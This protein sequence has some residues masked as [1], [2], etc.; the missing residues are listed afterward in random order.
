MINF[1]KNLILDGAMGTVLQEFVTLS[2]GYPP[3][4]LSIENSD[5]IC[6]IHKAYIDAGS[7]VIST[8]TFGANPFKHTEYKEMIKKSVEIALDAASGRCVA[9][10]I[11]PS[12][13]LFGETL[14]FDSCYEG[15]KSVVLAAEDKTDFILF[16]TFTDLRELRTAVLAAK[17]NS[18]LPVVACM[19]FSKNGRTP[20]GTDVDSFVLTVIAAGADG[21]GANCSVGP[22]EMIDVAK[23]M[24]QITDKPVFIQ[25]NAGIPI[26][27]NGV[28]VFPV[29]KE[30]FADL[31]AKIKA[32]GVR[33]IGGCCGTNPE[34]IKLLKEKLSLVECQ[35]NAAIKRSAVCCSQRTAVADKMLVVGER[36]NP[37]GKKKFKEAVINGDYDYITACGI[38]QQEE[39][40]DTLDVNVG[41]NGVDEKEVMQKVT[42]RLQTVTDLPL[43]IDTSSPA[44]LE[45]ALRRY[46]GKAIINSVNASK[47]SLEEVLPL[48]VRFGAAVIGLTLDENGI[49]KTVEGRVKLAKKITQECVKRGIAKED[50][51]IDALTLSE[52]SESGGALVTLNT[53]KEVKKLGVKTVLGVSNVSF[54]MPLRNDINAAFLKL[55]KEAGLDL[56]I[57]NPTF[58]N[59]KPS[60]QATDFILNREGATEAYLAYATGKVEEAL[61]GAEVTSDL[62]KAILTGQKELSG[63]I[64]EILIKENTAEE[65]VKTYV[66]PAL[67]EVGER[68]EKGEMFLPQLIASADAAQ[69]VFAVIEK[70]TPINADNGKR[71]VLAT[72][73]GDVH[74]IGKNILKSVV[75]N[76]GY[77]VIDLGRDVDYDV[78]LAAV[79]KNYPCVL[80]LSALMTTTVD[81]MEK[82]IKVVKSKFK[83]IKVLVGGA[84]LTADYAEKI[85]GIYCSD[86]N[87]TV[88]KLNYI[89][90]MGI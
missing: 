53:L 66:I 35:K 13:K 59:L 89:F 80:G 87:A 78:V 79:E 85:G 23:R 6:K 46:C 76:Y 84:V 82:T 24:V 72:V 25:A 49:P 30:E 20:F 8:N 56:A 50:I 81:N 90:D 42:E 22:K 57:I 41:V 70:D 83:D 33:A 36:I 86:A 67:D 68:Y 43:Q 10:D 47:K 7:D 3:E 64:A 12:G 65:I 55:A 88:K 63:K 51:Y 37:T 32:L 4:K 77:K 17:E 19:T 54:G 18:K 73:K 1:E 40:A 11:G 5:V 21:V 31:N 52:A 28:T 61:K 60:K 29:G 45:C 69:S 27:K 48:A 62:K 16:E 38:M 9:L 74:D 44:V 71:F 34:Y 26:L 58:K 2:A 14:D 39:G 75:G 15:Y